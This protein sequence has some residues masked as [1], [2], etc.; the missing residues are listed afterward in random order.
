MS[1]SWA[2]DCLLDLGTENPAASKNQVCK[3]TCL[4]LNT[5]H[6]WRAKD[7]LTCLKASPMEWEWEWE[8][9]NARQAIMKSASVQMQSKLPHCTFPP[10]NVILPGLAG[11]MEQRTCLEPPLGLP[12]I[13]RYV[14]C[15]ANLHRGRPY[16][17]RCFCCTQRTG[18]WHWD[19]C[20]F[21]GDPL[22]RG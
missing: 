12:R 11:G 1:L 18:E 7:V 21:Q 16:W 22:L 6:R 14:R 15:H 8:L 13:T 4:D 3:V 10:G 9:E 17:W 2:I 5:F 19:S 20:F